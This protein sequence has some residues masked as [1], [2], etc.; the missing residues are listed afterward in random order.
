M[1]DLLEA[2][3]TSIKTYTDALS[4][5]VSNLNNES[6]EG[7]K[8]VQYTFKSVFENVLNRG[9]A[10][11]SDRSATNPMQFGGRGM[12]AEVRTDFSQGKLI[13]AGDLDLAISGNGLFPL[14]SP[15]HR[16]TV[17]SRNGR[18]RVSADSS[19]LVDS[20]NR[21]LLGWKINADGSIDSSDLVE[22]DIAGFDDLGWTDDGMLVSGFSAQEDAVDF[23]KNNPDSP[24]DV[25][26]ATE[27][28][29]V[30]L[31]NFPN[32]SGLER[33]DGTA[34]RESD[35]SGFASSAT[36]PGENGLGVLS[37]QQYEDSNVFESG[38][39]IDALEVQR[40]M[41][42]SLTALQL[43]NRQMQEVVQAI[44]S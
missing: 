3:K 23:N 17:Y 40:A 34:F 28:Y 43:I 37:A 5:H 31:V 32:T 6:T 18:F 20:S 30:A 24:V 38:E 2:S 21:P 36:L 11:T 15:R 42:A 4:A 16:E 33:I 29:Q 1:L 44:A 27:L 14:Y 39:T 13:D 26:E 9:L 12:L 25:P 35:A 22:M 10:A 8:A 7:Y 41:S 19:Q